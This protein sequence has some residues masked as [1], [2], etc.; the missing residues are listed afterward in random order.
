[1]FTLRCRTGSSWYLA[2]FY[3]L[4]N[5]FNM[6]RSNRT[7]KELDS[8]WEKMEDLKRI[9]SDLGPVSAHTVE[10]IKAE[11]TGRLGFFPRFFVP[12][13]DSPSLLESL[14]RQQL[15]HYH[16]NPLPQLFKEKLA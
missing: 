5:Q 12:A 9:E 7:G 10:Q 3:L 13:L 1:M 6:E 14:W 16:E 4:R 2:A 11:I 15:F 8:L